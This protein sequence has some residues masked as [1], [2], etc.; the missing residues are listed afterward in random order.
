MWPTRRTPSQRRG[1]HR[2]E[3]D[4]V[5]IAAWSY[6]SRQTV[7]EQ[8]GAVD[9]VAQGFDTLAEALACGD[10]TRVLVSRS[11]LRQVPQQ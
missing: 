4:V 11:S 8:T 3:P 6:R 7:L 9:N 5:F 10:G 1:G 2:F